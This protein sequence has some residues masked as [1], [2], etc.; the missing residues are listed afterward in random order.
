MKSTFRG[1]YGTGKFLLKGYTLEKD[2]GARFAKKKEI[3]KLI[4]PRNKGVLIDGV[5]RRLSEKDSFRHVGIV[6]PPGGGKTTGYIL[7]NILD[8]AQSKC[9]MLITDPS[10]EIYT[11]TSAHLKSKGYAI[12]TLDPSNIETSARFNPFEDLDHQHLVEIERICASIILSKYGNDKDPL[13]NDGAISLLE[14]FAK[15]LAYSQPEYLNIPNLN[16]LVTKFGSDGSSLDNWVA[17]HSHH[18]NDP[19]DM[20]IVDAWNGIISGNKNML[21]SYTTIAKTALKQFNNRQIQK[22][23]S[24]NDI[25]FERF[26]EKKTAIYILLPE[27]QASYYQFLVDVFYTK[28]FAMM[29]AKLPT[30]RDLDVYCFLDEFGNAYVDKFSMIVNNVRKYRVS[31]SLVFQGIS[32]LSEKYGIERAKS[33]K[34]GISTMLVFGGADYETL[35]EQSV[36]I[37][38]KVT[39]QRKSFAESEISY[40]KT[41]LLPPDQIRTLEDNQFL[42]LSANNHPFLVE[43]TPFYQGS[44]P[45][46]R[47][48]KKGAFTQGANPT[49]VFQYQLKI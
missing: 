42:F 34:A 33:I 47:L 9:S 28:F 10:G 46:S 7:P 44:S 27:N 48:A 35:K 26:R 15:C 17:D 49:P 32:Q 19:D 6:S 24:S 1:L 16:Y 37:G 3:G 39:Q 13:W 11:A 18:P 20:S 8:K 4:N 38:D 36:A 12:I 14:V 41:A 21:S 5:K 43:F 29:M 31:L 40:A 45:F 30:R 25:G 2:I 23:F 22:L